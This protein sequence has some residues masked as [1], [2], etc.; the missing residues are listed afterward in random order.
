MARFGCT[1][2]IGVYA[3]HLGVENYAWRQAENAK[4]ALSAEAYGFSY[5]GALNALLWLTSYME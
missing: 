1:S 5:G 3:C 4:L 2:R